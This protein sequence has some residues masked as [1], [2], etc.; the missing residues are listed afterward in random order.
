[1]DM[2]ANHK[3]LPFQMECLTPM[4]HGKIMSGFGNYHKPPQAQ[5][6]ELK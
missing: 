6:E 1:M 4:D 3:A 5:A 2:A